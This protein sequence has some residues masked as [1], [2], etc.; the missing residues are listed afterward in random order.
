MH[1][2]LRATQVLAAKWVYSHTTDS[3]TAR[4]GIGGT[5]RQGR[6]DMN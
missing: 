4:G 2:G 5:G 6:G 3:L 1:G